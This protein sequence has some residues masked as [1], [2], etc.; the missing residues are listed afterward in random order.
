MIGTLRT[1]DSSALDLG[2]FRPPAAP[3]S[4][5]VNDADT[6]LLGQGNCQASLGHR[7][8]VRPTAKRKI[9]RNVARQTGLQGNIARENRRGAPEPAERRQSKP[10]SVLTAWSETTETQNDILPELSSF[11]FSSPYALFRHKTRTPTGALLPPGAA[12]PGFSRRTDLGRAASRAR[13]P[14]T[15]LDHRSGAPRREQAAALTHHRRD[16]PAGRGSPSNQPRTTGPASTKKP[17]G[18]IKTKTKRPATALINVTRKPEATWRES[19][20]TRPAANF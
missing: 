10:L 13:Q 15:T 9:Q 1:P 2:R 7:I 16:Y 12:L 5:F 18:P 6:A 20:R 11:P 8:H 19:S 17:T 4:G 3:A 14:G